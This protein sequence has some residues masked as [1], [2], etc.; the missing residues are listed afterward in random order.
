MLGIDGFRIIKIS[1]GVTAGYVVENG[2]V[3]YQPSI[4]YRIEKKNAFDPTII[5]KR[6]PY[7][8]DSIECEAYIK[9]EEYDNLLASLTNGLL[10]FIEF[11]TSETVIQ[12]PVTI[13]KLPKLEDLNRSYRGKIKFSLRSIYQ[14]ITPI[15][16]DNIFGWGTSWGKNYGF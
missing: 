14:E 16:F 10:Y 13:S 5:I 9:A 15:D 12:L 3:D 6:E 2:T 8:Y 11:D 7:H 4:K 1:A